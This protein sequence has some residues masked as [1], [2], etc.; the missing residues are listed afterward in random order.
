MELFAGLC[1]MVDMDL[2]SYYRHQ[3]GSARRLAG[4][5]QKQHQTKAALERVAQEYDGLADQLEKWWGRDP[6]QPY[7]VATYIDTRRLRQEFARFE[8][9]SF[10][11]PI[12]VSRNAPR[13]K[14]KQG[15][16]TDVETSRHT[17]QQLENELTR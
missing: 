10:D 8:A 11:H 9:T 17:S 12:K 2:S 14:V 15:R 4:V 7:A 3:A 1:C 13:A 6:E 16:R 5:H